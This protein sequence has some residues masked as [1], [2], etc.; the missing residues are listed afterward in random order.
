VH[1]VAIVNHRCVRFASS[2]SLRFLYFSSIKCLYLWQITGF[3][4]RKT[5]SIEDPRPAA[6]VSPTNN[7]KER[8]RAKSQ[9]P[10]PCVALPAPPTMPATPTTPA[11]ARTTMVSHSF[12][13][14]TLA[15]IL[16]CLLSQLRIE[17]DHKSRWYGPTTRS[18]H[19]GALKRGNLSAVGICFS[20]WR[21]SRSKI[22]M[23]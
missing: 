3:L 12:F 4:K 5:D 21:L 17:G 8:K 9:T 23:I 22:Q 14:V 20:R 16:R 1:L 19:T 11:V 6:E 15:H 13:S 2:R 18:T 7:G 10:P